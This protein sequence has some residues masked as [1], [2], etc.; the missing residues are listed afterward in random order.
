MKQEMAAL[1]EH[2]LVLYKPPAFA[3][4]NQFAM[5]SEKVGQLKETC[6]FP[7]SFLAMLG[8]EIMA[9][10]LQHETG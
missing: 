6:P 10:S 5:P 1:R 2:I 8:D 7:P 9:R 4:Y 3:L